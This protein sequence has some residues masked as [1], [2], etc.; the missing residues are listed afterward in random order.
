MSH[1][2][3]KAATW[4]TDPT[5]VERATAV[6][7]CIAAAVPLDPSLRM[8]EYGA[9]TGLV[10][11]ALQDAVGPVTL[12]DTSAGM[13]EVMQAKIASGALSDARVLAADLA[14]EPPPDEQFDLIVTVMTLHHI[15]DLASVLSAFALLL[16]PGGHLCIADLEKEDGSFHGADFDGHQ[17]FDRGELTN[18]LTAA[19]FADVG[20]SNCTALERDGHRYPVFLATGVRS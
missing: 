11:Q 16:P 10:T 18:A 7:R 13:R 8:M 12:V 3:D 1:F 6:A 17:G 4:D 9:G 5:K 2:D 20:F 14:A 19:G 15:P